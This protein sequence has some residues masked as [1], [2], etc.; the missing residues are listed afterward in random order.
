MSLY[1]KIY[2]A[3]IGK[4]V[5]MCKREVG[6]VPENRD[7]QK[8]LIFGLLCQKKYSAMLY[9]VTNNLTIL[10]DLSEV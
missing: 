10:T 8:W 2:I 7:K 3:K 6:K 1:F 4:I 5:D 9:I